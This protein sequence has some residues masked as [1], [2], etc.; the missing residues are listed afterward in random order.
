MTFLAVT[1]GGAGN[2]VSW[3]LWLGLG[4]MGVCNDGVG[5]RA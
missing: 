1:A 3:G 5:L 2:C 4:R